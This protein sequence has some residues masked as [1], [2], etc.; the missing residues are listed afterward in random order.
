MSIDHP[1]VYR[2]QVELVDGSGKV[3]DQHS[4]TFDCARSRS[5]SASSSERRAGAVDGLARHEDSPW[6]GLAETPGTMRHD[7]TT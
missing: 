1:N 3:L 2:M 7:L 4:D 6:E 5:G